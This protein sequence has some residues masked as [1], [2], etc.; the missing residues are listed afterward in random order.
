MNREARQRLLSFVGP[1]N[2]MRPEAFS[3]PQ[4]RISQLLASQAPKQRLGLEPR[5]ITRLARRVRAIARQQH[6]HVHL[7][8]FGFQPGE[9]TL[10]AVPDAFVP[11][12]FALDHPLAALGAELAPGC[13]QRNTALL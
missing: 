5:T 10:R 4:H 8:G 7:V 3:R 13:I 9:E 2:A 1:L 11:V 12:A 6:T